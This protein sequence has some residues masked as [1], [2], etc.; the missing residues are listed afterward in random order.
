MSY[1]SDP[2]KLGAIWFTIHIMAKH[3][4]TIERKNQFIDYM[5]L[6][7]A[8]FPC[9]KCRLHIQE[10]LKANPFEPFMNMVNEKGEDI[11]M[12][13]WSWLFHNT[14]NI[15]LNKPYVDWDTAWQM[16]DSGR[17]VCTNCG[18][19]NL[20]NDNVSNVSNDNVSNQ[21]KK[22][23]KEKIVKG[24]FLK[25]ELSNFQNKLYN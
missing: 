3:A 6:L 2:K 22:I 16:Y 9:G 12:F 21:D 24:Y 10:Y 7:S 25:K 4:D 19:S 13:N 1:P 20:S 15:R 14:V 5:Y 18:V 17:E 23:D 11:G 8:E